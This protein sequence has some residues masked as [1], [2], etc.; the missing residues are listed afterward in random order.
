MCYNEGMTAEEAEKLIKESK[1]KEKER[2]AKVVIDQDEFERYVAV[3][4]SIE[5][6]KDIFQATEDD[7][8]RWCFDTYGL[9]F[10]TTYNL[11]L[12]QALAEYKSA[13]SGL[14]KIG[15]NTAINTMNQIVLNLTQ[16]ND[17]K[18]TVNANIPKGDNDNGNSND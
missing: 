11:M 1:A 7:F 12:K 5:D 10:R 13:L 16:Q 9:N 3:A 18:I 8:D 6:L 14:A 4:T 15:N 2:A 17:L